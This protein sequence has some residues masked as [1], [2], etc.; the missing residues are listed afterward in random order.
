MKKSD[1]SITLNNGLPTIAKKRHKN[2]SYLSFCSDVICDTENKLSPIDSCKS[3]IQVS[4]KLKNKLDSE[5]C[6]LVNTS[7]GHFVDVIAYSAPDCEHNNIKIT[8]YVEQSLN[9]DQN[10][11]IIICK[12]NLCQ[13]NKVKVQTFNNIK[14][15]VMVLPDESFIKEIVN[16]FFLFEVIN[17]LTN[18]SIYIR[19]KHIIFDSSL[20]KNEIRLN[21]KQRNM[22]SDNIPVRLS[23]AQW[24]TL[25]QSEKLDALSKKTLADTYAPDRSG[26]TIVKSLDELNYDIRSSIQKY[27]KNNFGE[28]IIVRPVLESY[29]YEKKIKIHRKLCD[30]FVGKSTLSL[31]CRRPHE[32]DEN[33]DIVRMSESN[34]LFLGIEPMDKVIIRFKET[35]VSCHVLPFSEEKFG[36]TNIP[37]VIELSIGIPAHIR[38]ELNITDIQSSV[39]V[40][41]DTTFIFKKSFNDQLV[42]IIL[43]LLSLSFLEGQPWY[44]ILTII[45]ILVPIVM[46]ISL[47]SKRNM[48]GR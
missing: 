20:K 25:M 31:N 6:T 32:C 14:D 28:N 18:D 19:S 43:T 2:S 11:R 39:K 38:N 22:L 45:A 42:P 3:Y 35:E 21:K 17:P 12:Q 41:R 15:D 9:A 48:R 33:S 47:S 13:F 34:M 29:H 37:S 16:D 1:I 44:F 46:Y 40:D 26:Y 27:M 36:L 10:A 4:G 24:D 7:N 23:K 30:F 8:R 5:Y